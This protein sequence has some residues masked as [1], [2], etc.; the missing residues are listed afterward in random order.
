MKLIKKGR[1]QKGW[2]K[3]Y[4]CSGDGNGGGG[5]GAVLLVEKTDL[6]RTGRHYYDG[7]S[8]CFVTFACSACG[9]LTDVK[10]YPG[11]TRDL[12]TRSTRARED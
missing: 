3:E 8:D 12:P 2:A 11:S 1:P 5:C 10:D 6:F 4:A 9:V 7:S